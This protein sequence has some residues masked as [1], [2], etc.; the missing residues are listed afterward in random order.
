MGFRGAMATPLAWAM[1]AAALGTGCAGPREPTAAYVQQL[2]GVSAAPVISAA[3]IDRGGFDYVAF[4]RVELP[5]AAVDALRRDVSVL[6]ELPRPD[7]GEP[8]L[9]VRRWIAGPLSAEAKRA[10]ALA[11]AGAEAAVVDSGCRVTSAEAARQA[12]WRALARPTTFHSFA[13]WSDSADVQAEQLDF[14]ILDLEDGVL[15]E[16]AN[17]S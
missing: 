13:Y 3:C 8:H 9:R 7:P 6:L 5:V 1:F 12:I 2:L 4:R 17:H 15:Y 16:L 14:R 10:F 11:L